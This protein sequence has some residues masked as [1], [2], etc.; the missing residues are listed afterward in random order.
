[1]FYHGKQKQHKYS[2]KTKFGFYHDTLLRT[3]SICAVESSSPF[4]S[5][6][7]E[8]LVIPVFILNDYFE[9]ST[10]MYVRDLY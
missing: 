8:T 3:S 9:S 7:C 4:P 10:L 1:M 2:M 5:Q 6:S